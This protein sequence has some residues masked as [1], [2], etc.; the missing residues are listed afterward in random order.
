[1]CKA[2]KILF[3]WSN[4]FEKLLKTFTHTHPNIVGILTLTPPHERRG[5]GGD[6]ECYMWMDN[7]LV[8]N[9]YV[10]PS[11]QKSGSANVFHF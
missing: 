1:M 4:E 2:L 10:N 8:L 7:I 5:G 3:T 11:F 6:G 9:C